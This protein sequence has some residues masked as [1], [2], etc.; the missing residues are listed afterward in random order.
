VIMRVRPEQV[1]KL[2]RYVVDAGAASERQ[3]IV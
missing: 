3:V 1:S 2:L